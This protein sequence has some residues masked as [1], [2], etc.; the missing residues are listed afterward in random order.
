MKKIYSDS[1]NTAEFTYDYFDSLQLTPEYLFIYL[2]LEIIIFSRESI[3]LNFAIM[4]QKY[5]NTV[6]YWFL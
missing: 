2:F 1:K 6:V 4:V 3:F 5:N